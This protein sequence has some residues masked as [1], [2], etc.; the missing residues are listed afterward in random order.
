MKHVI[1]LVEVPAVLYQAVAG[2]N[3]AGYHHF[4]NLH[5]IRTSNNVMFF[6]YNETCIKRTPY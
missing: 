5:S 6:M 2:Q 4:F 3:P 1:L